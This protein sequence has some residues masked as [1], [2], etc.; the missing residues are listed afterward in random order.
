MCKGLGFLKVNNNDVWYYMYGMIIT[1][2]K[3]ILIVYSALNIRV[4][5]EYV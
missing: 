4:T 1:I 5:H 2:N 3:Y